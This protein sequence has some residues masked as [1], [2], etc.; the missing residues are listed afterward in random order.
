MKMNDRNDPSRRVWECPVCRCV[1]VWN[2]ADAQ[3]A[4]AILGLDCPE[5]SSANNRNRSEIQIAHGSA[6]DNI[7]G[8]CGADL[9]RADSPILAE[10]YTH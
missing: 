3:R 6:F 2:W 8:G 1:N 7:C 9:V 10:C 4:A 5:I